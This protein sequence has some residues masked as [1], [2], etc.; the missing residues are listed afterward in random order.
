MRREVVLASSLL[1]IS[2]PFNDAAA[3][4]HHSASLRAYECPG[5]GSGADRSR[6]RDVLRLRRALVSLSKAGG[7][8]AS[9]ARSTGCEPMH[10]LT[11]TIFIVE[12]LGAPIHTKDAEWIVAKI[13]LSEPGA[14]GYDFDAVVRLPL[15]KP[16]R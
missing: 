7:A 2:L 9:V 14:T 16:G 10:S 5:A 1:L 3:R 12:R 13:T 15:T 8:E 6:A 11:S 4:A